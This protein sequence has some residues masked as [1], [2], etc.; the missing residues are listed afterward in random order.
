M[1]LPM[2]TIEQERAV[3]ESCVTEAQ[4][5]LNTYR[6]E[7]MQIQADL[8]EAEINRM[9]EELSKFYPTKGE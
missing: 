4:K 8:T 9:L 2:V 7:G 3:L 1:P 5:R 6:A